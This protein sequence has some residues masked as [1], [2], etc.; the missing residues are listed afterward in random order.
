VAN[1]ENES[2]YIQVSGLRVWFVVYGVVVGGVF[3]TAVVSWSI[4]NAVVQESGEQTGLTGNTTTITGLNNLGDYTLPSVGIRNNR[5]EQI[6][7]HNQNKL[8]AYNQ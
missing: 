1:D 4:S 3:T 7:R 8:Y 6:H 2:V 5:N